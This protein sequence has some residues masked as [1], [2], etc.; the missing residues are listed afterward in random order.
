MGDSGVSSPDQTGPAGLPINDRGRRAA[1]AHNAAR[2]VGGWG[3]WIAIR[4]S[5]GTT[6]GVIYDDRDAAIAHQL[7]EQ[8]CFYVIV[9]PVDMTATEAT[10]LLNV[11]ERAY[12]AGFDFTN[13][14]GAVPIAPVAPPLNRA[15][16]GRN[17]NG[18]IVGHD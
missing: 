17:P 7:H 5:D 12:D 16:R 10:A 2:A 15:A 1:E 3:R 11:A 18:R 4:L 8:Q 9:H 6:D 13:P 14:A